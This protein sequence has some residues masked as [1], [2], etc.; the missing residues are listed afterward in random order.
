MSNSH[1]H[2]PMQ[3]ITQMGKGDPSEISQ[4]FLPFDLK[5]WCCR[6]WQLQRWNCSKLTFPYWRL[7]W[8]KNVGGK[9]E[10]MGHQV[11][12]TPDFV[13][14]IPPNTTFYSSFGST[15]YRNTDYEVMGKRIE[16]HENEA[17]IQKEALLH[18]FIHFNLGIPYDFVKPGIY[19][20]KIST[21]QQNK[22]TDITDILKINRN[23]D[24]TANF[25]VQSAI[26]EFLSQ[27]NID[28]QEAF[29]RDKR[30]LKVIQHILENLTE[31]YSNDDL[32]AMVNM[33]PN[34]FSRL[35]KNNM[36]VTLQYFVKE[37]KIKTACSWFDH[38]DITIEEVADALGFSDRYHFSRI[39]KQVKSIS[40]GQY[41]KRS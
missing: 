25:Y 9:I 31:S 34:S 6:Y 17:I 27:S 38:K 13:Y 32:A 40:P 15:Q 41:L 4:T 16:T 5:L 11:D 2:N 29:N 36:G 24:A 20:I 1:Q 14:L 30:V 26:L 35:F 22:L 7:Y 23:L 21:A 12:M 3:L 8:N 33:T 37:Q 39:F 18:L 28:F 10:Y 19:P